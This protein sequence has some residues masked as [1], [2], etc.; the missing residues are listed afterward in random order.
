MYL[1]YSLI[2]AFLFGQ[3]FGLPGVN[4]SVLAFLQPISA[5]PGY[6]ARF[7]LVLSSLIVKFTNFPL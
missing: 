2:F 3:H 6:T 5:A 7:Q 4:Q 1:L